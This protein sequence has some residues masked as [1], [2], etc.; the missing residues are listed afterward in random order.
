MILTGTLTAN[1]GH[2]AIS[3]HLNGD[4]DG[5]LNHDFNDETNGDLNGNTY[6]DLN[7][8]LPNI[9]SEALMVTLTP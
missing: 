6:G 4:L 5:N 9:L 1:M 2:N 7:G 8:N 3:Y